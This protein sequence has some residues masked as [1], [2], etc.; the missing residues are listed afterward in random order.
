M[1]RVVVAV[2]A[3]SDMGNA[4]RFHPHHVFAKT[5][6]QVVDDLLV[7]AMQSAQIPKLRAM[8]VTE[9]VRQGGAK[10]CECFLRLKEGRLVRLMAVRSFD[11]AVQ[12][13][14]DVTGVVV[15]AVV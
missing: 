9:T 13:S 10:G 14:L 11:H 4:A 8:V 3:G 12:P 7:V 1:T 5:R 15:L 2:V 6:T